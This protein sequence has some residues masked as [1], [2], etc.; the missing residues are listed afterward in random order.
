MLQST[1]RLPHLLHGTVLAAMIA[2]AAATVVPATKVVPPPTELPP[3]RTAL[4][5]FYV[6]LSA[7]T[8]ALVFALLSRKK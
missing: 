5:T 3:D 7:W 2:L 6:L 8:T 1:F 4:Q